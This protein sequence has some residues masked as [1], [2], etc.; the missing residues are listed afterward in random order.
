LPQP[1]L[2]TRVALA[3]TASSKSF[4]PGGCPGLG[5][6][7]PAGE[8]AHSVP[9]FQSSNYSYPDA[10]AADAAAEGA[11]FL[12]ARHGS[13]TGAALEAALANLEGADVALGFGSGMGALAGALEA[14]MAAR[15]PGEGAELLASDGIY[16]GSTELVSEIA[17]RCGAST[18]F[19]PAWETA[20]VAAAIGPKTRA[21]LIETMSNPLLRVPE[22]GRL[23]QLCRARGVALVVDATAT[24]PLLCQPLA[25]GASLVVHSLSKYLGGHGDLIGGLVAGEAALMARVRRQRTLG[26]AVL[27]PFAAWLALRG[28]RTLAVRLERQCATAARLARVLARHPGVRAVHYP[29]LG[30]HPDRA[31]ARALFPRGANPGALISFSLKNAAAAR[32]F[33]DR[34]TLI[35]RAASFGETNSLLTHPA[36]F[37]HKGLSAAERARLGIDDSLL[38][39]SV[40]VE[41]PVDLEADIKQALGR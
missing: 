16:G 15:A 22:L 5:P 38:R 2:A 20:V 39:L 41:A 1:A 8:T 27:D 31:R 9:I 13:P 17:R 3:G 23:G 28:L 37:S 19:V 24:T 29:G 21:L 33:Y 7:G 14:V 36:S 4:L 40:G 6:L 12:Y 30:T 18:R 32:R 26:G 35:A 10:R 11:A 25:H 34:V